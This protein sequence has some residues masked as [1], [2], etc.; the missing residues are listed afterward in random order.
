M[1]LERKR[2]GQAHEPTFAELYSPK[3]VTVLREGYTLS[4]LRA[5]AFSGLT[6]AIVALPLSM[7]IAIASGATPDR[8]LITAVVG[9]FIVSLGGALVLLALAG[10]SFSFQQSATRTQIYP[11]ALRLPSF[12]DDEVFID[13]EVRYLNAEFERDVY[14]G[15]HTTRSNS[16]FK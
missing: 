3:L 6:V 4:D 7:A 1:N 15:L 14:G 11:V 12:E 8:G 5:D 10:R 16:A 13:N 2:A 9:G